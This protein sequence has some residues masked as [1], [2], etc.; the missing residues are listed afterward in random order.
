MLTGYKV[1]KRSEDGLISI[2]AR[3]KACVTYIPNEWIISNKIISESPLFVFDTFEN[4]NNFRSYPNYEIWKCS[5][6]EEKSPKF[7]DID[8]INDL[9][10]IQIFFNAIIDGTKFAKKIK[11]EKRM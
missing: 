5:Y 1:I 11:L 6:E 3:G 7:F 2:F 10:K 4:A 9:K 8:S